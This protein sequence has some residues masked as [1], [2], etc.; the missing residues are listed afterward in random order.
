MVSLHLIKAQVSNLNTASSQYRMLI[1]LQLTKPVSYV[2]VLL[3]IM[4]CQGRSLLQYSAIIFTSNAVLFSPPELGCRDNN[5]H[6]SC[7]L[8]AFSAYDS[9]H[10]M[11]MEGAC[12]VESPVEDKGPGG[13]NMVRFFKSSY[14]AGQSS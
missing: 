6:Q 4:S 2:S 3:M 7:Y 13:G 11:G 9:L 14:R 8:T 5:L 10:A 12:L 1:I